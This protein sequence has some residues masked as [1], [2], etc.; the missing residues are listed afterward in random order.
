MAGS[1]ASD[2]YLGLTLRNDG[3]G[4][5]RQIKVTFHLRD[6]SHFVAQGN[7]LPGKNEL[8]GPEGR[9]GSY[10]AGVDRSVLAG[11]DGQLGTPLGV[12]VRYEWRDD[13]TRWRPRKRRWRLPPPTSQPP[14]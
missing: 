5:A 13:A 2:C 11:A 3:P 7:Y 14:A 9:A 12:V 10:Q 6:G 8:Q 1:S 4:T